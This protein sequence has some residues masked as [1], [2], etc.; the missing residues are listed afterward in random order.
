M[1]GSRLPG[2]SSMRGRCESP[3]LLEVG[4]EGSRERVMRNDPITLH[5][6]YFRVGGAGVGRTKVNLRINS[7]DTLV[8]HTWI[9]RADHGDW[10]GL[11][12]EHQRERAG[13]EWQPGHDLWPVCGTSPAISGSVERAM[14]EATYFYQSEIPYDPPNQAMY[15]S[16]P[17]S[18]RLGVVQS[19]G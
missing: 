5:D 3:V 14:A 9:W 16:A 6:V 13:G 17:G 12:A 2:C 19:G 4:P 15:T 10:R 7:N 8:D 1:T 11:G 18:E